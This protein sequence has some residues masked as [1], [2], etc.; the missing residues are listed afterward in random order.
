MCAQA[1]LLSR[2]NVRADIRDLPER[3]DNFVRCLRATGNKTKTRGISVES[4]PRCRFL[5]STRYQRNFPSNPNRSLDIID[6]P[7]IGANLRLSPV[8]PHYAMAMVEKNLQ[9]T[10]ALLTERSY[11]VRTESQERNICQK[12]CW[13]S[14]LRS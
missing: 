10:I 4:K 13:A 5:R 2:N 1:A 3:I 12:M 9:S 6:Y 14:R 8:K 11:I 7:A